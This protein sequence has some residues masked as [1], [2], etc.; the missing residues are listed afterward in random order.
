[1]TEGCKEG[2]RKLDDDRDRSKQAQAENKSQADA[3]AP[4]CGL[5]MGRQLVGQ[6]RDEDEVVDPEHDLHDDEGRQ[7]RPSCRVCSQCNNIIHEALPIASCLIL[8]IVE[9]VQGRD[10]VRMF[11]SPFSRSADLGFGA[12]EVRVP[13]PT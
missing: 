1:M 6:N 12:V 2:L 7:G 4:G 9:L 13:G 8:V 3:D 10:W 11:A 5:L